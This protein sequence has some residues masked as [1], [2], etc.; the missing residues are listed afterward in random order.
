MKRRKRM[1][2]KCSHCG[3]NTDYFDVE[4]VDLFQCT[5]AHLP[6][7]NEGDI[8]FGDYDTNYDD[9]HDNYYCPN[10]GA[11]LPIHDEEAL[12][13]YVKRKQQ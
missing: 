7:D 5:T 6:L 10:C 3:K 11:V 2:Y 4:I 9:C 13:E 8:L 12:L 1:E